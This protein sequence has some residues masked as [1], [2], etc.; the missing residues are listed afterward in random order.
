ML[1]QTRTRE[2]THSLDQTKEALEAQSAEADAAREEA[3]GLRDQQQR[4][5]A[6]VEH[7]AN[8]AIAEEREK[9]LDAQRRQQTRLETDHRETMEKHEADAKS[10]REQLAAVTSEAKELTSDRHRLESTV[11]ELRI[12]LQSAETQVEELGSALEATRTENRKLDAESHDTTKTIH[13][14]NATRT[15][16]WR[17]PWRYWRVRTVPRGNWRIR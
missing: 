8:M 17:R 6:D 11:H 4:S 10:V 14:S 12:K 7:R 3:Q 5:H 16:C 15:S 1:R 9:A 13:S 2:L